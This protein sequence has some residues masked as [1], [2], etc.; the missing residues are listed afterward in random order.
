MGEGDGSA[1]GDVR[2]EKGAS[3]EARVP[4]EFRVRRSFMKYP[5]YSGEARTSARAHMSEI[6]ER[7]KALSE[8]PPSHYRLDIGKYVRPE[9]M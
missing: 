1:S 3:T 5:I 7:D 9:E 6:S 8:N 4:S 2:R